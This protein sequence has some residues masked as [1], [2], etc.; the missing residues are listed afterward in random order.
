M[1]KYG[2]NQRIKTQ[3]SR[4]V[5]LVGN[6]NLGGGRLNGGLGVFFEGHRSSSKELDVLFF[7]AVGSLE[8]VIKFRMVS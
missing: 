1:G 7:G 3:K 6:D 8:E 5:S 2:L 4:T